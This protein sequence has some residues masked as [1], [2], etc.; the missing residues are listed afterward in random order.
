MAR[1]SASTEARIAL[2]WRK[3]EERAAVVR[4]RVEAMPEAHLDGPMRSAENQI[5]LRLMDKAR[6]AL[7][8]IDGRLEA[9]IAE[10]DR[11][12]VSA[13]AEEQEKLLAE[14]GVETFDV[15]AVKARDGWQWLITRKP[16]RLTHDQIDAGNSYGKLFAQALRDDMSSSANDN[17]GIEGTESPVDARMKARQ[18]LDVVRAHI[19]GA[20][21]SNRLVGLL[22]AVCGRGDTLRAMAGNDERKAAGYEI[23]FKIALDMVG[24][25]LRLAKRAENEAKAAA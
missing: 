14:R 22:D 8:I 18:R 15:G 11:S 21:G 17:C 16:K 13:A 3:L 25:A 19:N 1:L 23:E 24:V 9:Y 20:T 12:E 10:R 4:G 5:Q 6:K 7:D 2:E